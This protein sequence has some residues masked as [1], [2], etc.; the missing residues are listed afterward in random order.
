M[1]CVIS[2]N[3]TD[4]K[5]CGASDPPTWA[6]GDYFTYGIHFSAQGYAKMAAHWLAALL[7]HLPPFPPPD[8]TA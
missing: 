6:D 2:C 4:S 5:A 8:D 3:R 7:P 1:C